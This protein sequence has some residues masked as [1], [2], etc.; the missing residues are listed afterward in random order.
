MAYKGDQNLRTS[1]EFEVAF[2]DGTTAWVNY[3]SQDIYLPDGSLRIIIQ[4]VFLCVAQVD[5]SRPTEN[6][7]VGF[8]RL[9]LLFERFSKSKVDS[10]EPRSRKD[11]SSTL[12]RN[13]WILQPR[14]R[15]C[16]LGTE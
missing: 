8:S 11:S 16:L 12:G 6:I 14:E 7:F 15:N 9:P 10:S 1:M 2:M 4:V 5:F 13:Y 3:Y